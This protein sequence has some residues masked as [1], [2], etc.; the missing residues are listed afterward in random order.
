MKVHVSRRRILIKALIPIRT[1]LFSW[2]MKP[3]GKMTAYACWPM[4]RCD[5]VDFGDDENNITLS[6]GIL[7]SRAVSSEQLMR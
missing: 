2:R 5:N 6:K 4:E 7:T 3:S 1:Q